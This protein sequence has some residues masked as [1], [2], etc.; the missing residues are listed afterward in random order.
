MIFYKEL[1]QKMFNLFGLYGNVVRIK[2]MFKNRRN[3]LV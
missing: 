2:I 3:A 1:H